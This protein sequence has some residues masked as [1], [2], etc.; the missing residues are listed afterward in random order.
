MFTESP[1]GFPIYTIMLMSAP[2]SG[3]G[4]FLVY[5]GFV[6][7]ASRERERKVCTFFCFPLPSD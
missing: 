6:S 2:I 7:Q 4:L 1:G 5:G 3:V